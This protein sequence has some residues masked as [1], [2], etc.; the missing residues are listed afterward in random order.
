[1]NTRLR[2][3]DTINEALE[4]AKLRAGS[5]GSGG[6]IDNATRQNLRRELQNGANWTADEKTA[7]ERVI[8]GTTGQN[9]LRQV[10]KLSPQGSGLMTAL[11][12]GG[13]MANP[14]L[15]IPALVGVGAKA[16]ADRSTSRA[17]DDFVRLI[18]GGGNKSAV[19]APKNA[20]QRL[21]ETKRDALVRLLMSGGLVAAE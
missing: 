9:A 18:A 17:V 14:I 8:M 13:A 12:V 3:T 7:L 16:A 2:K 5:T 20:V 11:G 21:S 15:G 1:M 10:G 4:A 6:N 19:S